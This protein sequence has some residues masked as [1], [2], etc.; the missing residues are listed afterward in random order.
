[1][2]FLGFEGEFLGFFLRNCLK[3]FG[4]D[5]IVIMGDCCVRG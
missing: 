1:M 4:L 5:S 3:F 2:G